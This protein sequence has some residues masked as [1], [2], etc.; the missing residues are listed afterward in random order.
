MVHIAKTPNFIAAKLSS[1][2]RY[3]L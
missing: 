1:F 3:E 2:T